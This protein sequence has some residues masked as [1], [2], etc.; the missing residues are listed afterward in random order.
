MYLEHF[1]LR[2]HP[3]RTNPNPRFLWFG[4]KHREAMAVLNYGVLKADGFLLLTGDVGT[5]KTS[6]IRNLVNTIE[7]RAR[8]AFVPDPD[9]AGL[10]FYNTLAEA[11][12]MGRRFRG[13]S[14]FLVGFKQ[15]LLASNSRNKRV[16]LIID[17]AQRLNHALLEQIRLLSNI[18]LD[19]KKLMLVFLVGQDEVE[20]LLTEDRNRAFRQRITTSHRL[21]PL[22]PAETE[23]YIAH[24]LKVAG[25]K[26]GIFTLGAC[27]R[28]F[29]ASN[30]IPR[31]INS[32]CD[33]GLLSGYV[34]DRQ[35]V[36]S[37]LVQECLI[38]LRVPLG[39]KP[40]PADPRDHSG[41]ARGPHPEP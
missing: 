6:L 7:D 30:G 18:E 21:E 11:F 36:D 4:E 31:L 8:I 15:F 25:A 38:D 39:R 33:C 24:R 34:K 1:A 26:R 29:E 16:F 9:L 41:E 37:R 22:N 27:R 5:G 40:K 28:I 12:G 32:L 19:E 20:D 3:F 13:K 14:D 35:R 10:D 23:R 2:E 17:E